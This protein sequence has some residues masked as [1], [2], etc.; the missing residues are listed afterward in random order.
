MAKCKRGWGGGGGGGGGS[1]Q[2]S[3]WLQSGSLSTLACKRKVTPSLLPTNLWIFDDQVNNLL[4]L[5]QRS[6]SF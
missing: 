5:L 3:L 1:D 2:T 4:S 6:F